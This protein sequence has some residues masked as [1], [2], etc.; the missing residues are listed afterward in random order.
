[1]K[2]FYIIAH[3]GVTENGLLENSLESL[4]D[5]K[6]IKSQYNLGIEFDIQLTLDN[7]I[8]IFHDEDI[9][10]YC[11]EKTDYYKIKNLNK[12]IIELKDILE[13]FNNTNFILNIELKNYTNNK[14]RQDIFS[15]KVN[16]LVCKFNIKYYYSSFSKIIVNKLN[17]LD[18]C[19]FISEEYNDNNVS[20]TDYNFIDYYDNIVGVYTLYNDN[21]FNEDIIDKLIH[22]GVRYFITDN[23]EKLTNY[24][25]KDSLII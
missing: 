17:E 4:N 5:I 8:I 24:L 2:D 22:K 18:K 23:V 15:S 20:I 3:R 21:N 25:Y 13:D 10:G 6:N 12:N 19:Y 7:R 1:M 9:Q 11:I 16:D 14:N